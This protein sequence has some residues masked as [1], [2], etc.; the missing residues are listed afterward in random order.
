MYGLIKEQWS[1]G[2]KPGVENLVR[3]LAKRMSY[4]RI[5]IIHDRPL[6]FMPVL[7]RRWLKL[8]RSVERE[9]SS[10]ANFERVQELNAVISRMKSLRFTTNWPPDDY[11]ADVY[12]ATPEQARRY[13]PECQTMYVLCRVEPIEL[14]IMTSW[15]PPGGLVVT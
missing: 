12:L 13:A 4:G 14:H 3:R 5:V 11:L 6:V 1:L 8:T 2:D 10:T 9:R 15:M 7:R